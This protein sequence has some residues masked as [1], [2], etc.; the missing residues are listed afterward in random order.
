[1]TTK[2]SFRP[3]PKVTENIQH[4][5]GMLKHFAG[6]AEAAARAAQSIA[7]FLTGDY[8]RSIKPE[9]GYDGDG[10]IMARVNAWDY[11]AIWLEFG[12]E[13]TPTFA[14]L[15]RGTDMTGLHVVD[16]KDFHVIRVAMGQR[17]GTRGRPR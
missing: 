14:T 11:K 15:R 2:F 6:A 13:D 7:P 5:A 16:S 4:T 9:V 12:T 3:D 17:I 1:M 10:F 8:M